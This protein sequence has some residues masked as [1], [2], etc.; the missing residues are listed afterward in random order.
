MIEKDKPLNRNFFRTSNTKKLLNKIKEAQKGDPLSTFN[1]L[2]SQGLTQAIGELYLTLPLSS[3][4]SLQG[5]KKVS[6]SSNVLAADLLESKAYGRLKSRQDQLQNV[7]YRLTKEDG[8]H[9]LKSAQ[10]FSPL[11]KSTT[12]LKGSML[13]EAT[14][15]LEQINQQIKSD[16]PP[17]C[18][19]STSRQPRGK[20]YGKQSGGT[21]GRDQEMTTTPST[22]ADADDSNPDTDRSSGPRR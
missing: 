8:E 11:L 7:G 9:L 14:T 19:Q 22:S 1:A 17:P 13:K 3:S 15:R 20:V 4:T 12:D 21:S 5:E 6:S 18:Y 10:T 2:K 16:A